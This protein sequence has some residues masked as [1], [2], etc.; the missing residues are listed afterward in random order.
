MAKKRGFTLVEVITSFV[1][2]SICAAMVLVTL[3]GINKQ[4]GKERIR[5]ENAFKEQGELEKKIAVVEALVQKKIKQKEIINDAASLSSAVSQAQLVLASVEAELKTYQSASQNIN[6]QNIVYYRVDVPRYNTQGEHIDTLTSWVVES[7]GLVFPMPEIEKLEINV[8]GETM[9]PYGIKKYGK[10]MVSNV[11]YGKN[12]SLLFKEQCTWYV[13]RPGF[14]MVVPK[15][16]THKPKEKDI[17]SVY[18]AQGKDFRFI[19]LPGGSTPSEKNRTLSRIRED[20]RGCFIACG[21]KPTIKEGKIG[22]EAW[23]N[24]YYIAD[25]PDNVGNVLGDVDASL[26]SDI[27]DNCKKNIVKGIYNTSRL[28][29]ASNTEGKM[30][31]PEITPHGEKTGVVSVSD[32]GGKVNKFD[33]YS[34]YFHFNENDAYDFSLTTGSLPSYYTVYVVCKSNSGTGTLISGS[35]EIKK[36][37]ENY[38]LSFNELSI[39]GEDDKKLSGIGAN[40]GKWHVI[41]LHFDRTGNSITVYRDKDS[42]KGVIENINFTCTG[43]SIRLGKKDDGALSANMNVAEVILSN[44]TVDEENIKNMMTHLRNKYGIS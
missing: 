19:T 23:S 8:K 6:G 33:T 20:M 30:N 43:T 41:A 14:H 15:G 40:D 16:E 22:N 32:T 26:E 35:V 5:T 21:I 38:N 25:F 29:Q 31:V 17:G 13:S 2:I 42:N 39:S 28:S 36:Q 24:L 12:A 44:G 4:L 9:E 37:K 7:K 1:V 18:P 34:R 3:N 11:K 10:E 27:P